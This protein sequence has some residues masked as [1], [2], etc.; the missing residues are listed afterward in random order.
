MKNENLDD[1][2]IRIAISLSKL[3]NSNK[4]AV[5]QEKNYSDVA[6][7]YNKISLG[8]PSRKATVSDIFNANT[9]ANTKTLFPVIEVMGYTLTEFAVVYD[10]VKNDEI[11]KFKKDRKIKKDA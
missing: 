1:I 2:K 5:N 8:T 6:K 11:E 4:D 9:N 7:S 3:L 10:A